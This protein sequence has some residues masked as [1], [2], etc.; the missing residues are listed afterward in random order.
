M[1]NSI[2]NFRN[3]NYFINHLYAYT[4]LLR[5]KKNIKRGRP[6]LYNAELFL[7]T[8]C[9]LRCVH[10][11]ISKFQGQ[12]DYKQQMTLEDITKVADQLRELDCF[13]C[14]LVGGEL[15]LR[16]DLC[17]IINIFHKRKI[18]PTII[19]NGLLIDENLIKEMKKAGIFKIGISLN[20]ATAEAH[21][22]FVR[23]SGAFEKA[24]HALE[25]ISNS[26]VISS[27][28][29]VPTHENIANGNYRK[30]IEMAA[31][32]NIK[33]NVNYPALA[34]EYTG[35]YEMLLTDEELKEVREYFKLPHVTSDFTV[36]AD[37]YECPAGRKKIYILPD[38]SVCPCTFIHISF[39]NILTEDLAVVMGRIWSTDIFMSR[40][41]CCVVSE[42]IEFNEK[43][44]RPV[45]ESKKLPLYYSEHPMF[46]MR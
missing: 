1:L 34:G 35:N 21:D 6:F 18:L 2:K 46:K 38:G 14:C 40:P 17:E 24:M 44:L 32:R 26:G 39:G 31:N 30:L 23:R 10:C 7:D 15:T 8:R 28:C 36:Y 37:K 41:N 27:I 42:S 43:Y 12:S 9:N 5:R 29:I 19:T 4:N 45:F 33:V 11:S 25:L 20:D 22:S 3:A 13:L 16:K